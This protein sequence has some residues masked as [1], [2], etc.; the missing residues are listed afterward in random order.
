MVSRGEEERRCCIHTKGGVT[1]CPSKAWGNDTDQHKIWKDKVLQG[2]SE[3]EY[4]N[5]GIITI[6]HD[7]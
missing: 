4:H 5:N 6:G 1:K 2:Q 7:M 3:V